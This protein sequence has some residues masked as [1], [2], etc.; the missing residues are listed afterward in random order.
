MSA[1]SRRGF[2]KGAAMAPLAAKALTMEQG[3]T[4]A[5]AG[6]E[7]YD[8]VVAG[9]GHNS[10]VAAAYLAKAG[11]RCLVLEGRPVV[12]GGAKTAE[13]TL[14]G[15]KHDVCSSAHVLIQDSPMMRNDEL[16]LSE[17]GLEYI[18]PDPVVHI[19]FADGS[20]ITQWRDME[21][22]CAEFARF[23]KKDAA[24][25]KRMLTEYAE[26]APVFGASAYT[27]IG[28][29][30]PI[31]ELLA[32][33]P[34]G[35]LWQRRMAMSAWEI[36]RD[37]FED[38]HCRAFMTWMAYQ[39]VVP[40][41]DA[42]TGRLAY[43]LVSGRQRWSWT[44]P[45]GG[46]GAL[47]QALARLIE[48][49]GGTILTN[50]WVRKLIVEN[51]KCTGVECDDGN[52]YRA[53]KAVLSTIHIKHLV[54]MAPKEAFGQEFIQGVETWQAGITLFVTHY[55]TTE[56]PTFAVAGGTISPVASGTMVTPERALRVAYDFACKRVNVE[57]P[58]LLVVCST[59]ADPSRAP[60]GIHTI[61]VIG[62]QPYELKEGPEH[63]D[64]IKNQVADANLNYLRKFSPN[65]TD[66]KILARIVES[67]L[68]LERMNPHNWH[69]TC[70]GG[71]QDAAQ[72]GPL[73]PVPGW[74]QHRM[75]IPGLYQTGATTHPGGSV[76]GGPGRNAAIVM[77]K[78]FGKSLEEVVKKAVKS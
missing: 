72:S 53:E 69:G 10:L 43:A 51:G 14:P 41:E 13:L 48:A 24:A 50:K 67:P 29:G 20:Y 22:T 5:V 73:R 39:T 21:R 18:L 52:A 66:D 44:T 32:A 54:D 59:V 16:G 31:N 40:P 25:Y 36:I 70:H 3:G 76:S 62:N 58:P 27:P 57:E 45:K 6:G 35:K 33:H 56:P 15:V 12:G 7:K 38:E 28:L 78:D 42:M 77:L 17:Y 49:H 1:M 61:K 11:Y 37:N 4:P 9:A 55:T 47:T 2:V 75:P 26:I 34:K 46:S 19:P 74:A 71:A 63:W 64:T 8:V 65:L 30:K 60:K 68:D 23:S